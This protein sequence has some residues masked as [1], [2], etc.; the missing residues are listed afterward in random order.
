[1]IKLLNKIHVMNKTKAIIFCW[2]L[3]HIGIKRGDRVELAVKSPVKMVA[4]KNV[5]ITYTDIKVMVN[6]YIKGKLQK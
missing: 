5:K 2:I 1:M 4:D 6:E 3:S